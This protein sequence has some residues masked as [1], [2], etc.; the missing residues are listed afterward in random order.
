MVNMQREFSPS[1]IDKEDYESIMVGNSRHGIEF[2][3]KTTQM[4]T[5][6]RLPTKVST[7][8]STKNPYL[9]LYLFFQQKI[10]G[11]LYLKHLK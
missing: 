7:N 11:L 5:L 6:P 8:S 2:D 9:F 1:P 10:L 3:F 4:D